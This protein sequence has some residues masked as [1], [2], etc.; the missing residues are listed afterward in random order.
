[1]SSSDGR[2]PVAIGH[3]VLGS[4]D[5]G[6]STEF[7]VRAGLRPIE[8]GGEVSVLELRGGTH[9]IVLPAEQPVLSGAKAAFDLMVDDIEATHARYTRLDL[10]PSKG[11]NFP[12]ARFLP[13]SSSVLGLGVS[14]KAKVE[15]LGSLPRFS[16][17]ARIVFSSS[18]SGVS[19]PASSCSASSRLP[20]A[21][22]DLRLFVLSPD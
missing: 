10:A 4:P 7:L 2:P 19:A 6:A 21:S 8:T 15:R 3:V 9:L 20:Q 13:K 5:V 14:V 17:S 22:T 11:S 1:M 18:S 12:S 16:I